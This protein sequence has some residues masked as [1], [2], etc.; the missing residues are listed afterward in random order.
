MQGT[1]MSENTLGQDEHARALDRQ[2]VIED[3]LRQD[4]RAMLDV[5]KADI[6]SF[7]AR[8]AKKRFVAAADF[9]EKLSPDQLAKFKRDITSVGNVTAADVVRSLEDP[10]VWAWEPNTPLPENP[11]G[12][13]V[14]PRV[15]PVI[16]RIG[17]GLAQVL[18][19]LGFPDAESAKEAYK[20]PT[21]FVAGHLMKSRVESYWRNLQELVELTRLIDEST[22]RERREK[23]LR[24]W[25]E[26]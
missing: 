4:I 12:L 9:A 6:P 7:F 19:Q 15:G 1:V 13:E 26:A 17:L 21:F 2:Q 23:L 16:S 18:S 8:E 5:L 10:K 3:R 22:G 14:H 24:K 20:L 11:Q 25:D